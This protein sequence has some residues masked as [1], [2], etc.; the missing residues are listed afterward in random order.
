VLPRLV[1]MLLRCKVFRFLNQSPHGFCAIERMNGS[2]SRH[3]PVARGTAPLPGRLL[4]AIIAKPMP[5]KI[6]NVDMI[7]TVIKAMKRW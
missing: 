2:V 7:T 3:H 4:Y 6:A 1:A 5:S